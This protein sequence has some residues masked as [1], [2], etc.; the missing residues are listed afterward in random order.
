MRYAAL[1][2]YV[3]AAFDLLLEAKAAQPAERIEAELVGFDATRPDARSVLGRALPGRGAVGSVLDGLKNDPSV[4]A[5][6]AFW[7]AFGKLATFSASDLDA[8]LREVFDLASYRLD[9]WI[10]SLA[11]SRLDQTRTTNPNGGVVIGGYGWVENVRPA[12]AAVASSGYLQAP[13]IDRATTAAVLRSGYLAHAGDVGRPL[14]LDLSSQRVR[15][16]LHLLDGMRSGQSLGARLGYR[17]ER[18]LHEA[19]L[20]RFIDAFRAVEPSDAASALDVVDGLALVRTF[21]TSATFWN[22]AGLP[23]SGTPERTGTTAALE[24]LAAALDAVADLTLA[25]SVHQL[26][27]GNTLRASATL[28]AIARGDAPPP[29]I[30]F[31]ATSRSGNAS[32]YRVLS[33]ALET[34]AT[35][36]ASTPR[37]AAEPRLNG[38][39]GALLGDPSRVRLRASFAA[40]ASVAVEFGFTELGLAPLDVLALPEASNGGPELVARILAASSNHRPAGVAPDSVASVVT[41]RNQAWNAQTIGLT[42]WLVLAR[43][44]ARA[45]NGARALTPAD[46]AGPSDTPFAVDT[47]ELQARAD[48]AESHVRAACTALTQSPPTAAALLDAA[49]FGVT[50][51]FPGTDASSWSAQAAAAFANLTART[52]T[53]D[54]LASGFDRTTAPADAQIAHD[55]ARLQAT[56]GSSF[57]ALPA[58]ATAATAP[59]AQL[60]TNSIS[61][62]GTDAFAPV[63]FLQ[64]A[65]RVRA[66]VD[67]MDATMLLAESLAGVPFPLPGVAQVLAAVGDR[68]GELDT[69]PPPSSST[70]SLISWTPGAQPGGHRSRGC[71]LTSGSMSCPRTPKRRASHSTT[72]IQALALLKQS[73]SRSHLTRF[74]TFTSEIVLVSGSADTRTT[75]NRHRKGSR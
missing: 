70:L 17:F 26:T 55:V 61:L 40:P 6:A 8:A 7:K 62:Q 9:A 1:R 32:T 45:V 4:P 38:W 63:R 71:S 29:D 51:A 65:A 67:R 59:L 12:T 19:V 42:E 23:A 68:W 18:A 10:S 58:L 22:A 75:R 48:A 47:A 15:L 20:D 21:Q 44:T 69:A 31:V 60:W 34:T 73:C 27:R 57:V 64:Q 11:Q 49:S 46:F 53:L 43:A 54:A 35:G 24:T 30:D 28:D 72:P 33:L 41:E 3:D 52:T 50:G 25:E 37:A 16:G 2:T 66:G 56:F 39:A 74:R 36:W 13:S 14:A 5:F